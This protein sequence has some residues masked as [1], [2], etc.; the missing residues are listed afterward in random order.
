MYGNQGQN[1]QG[2]NQ[3]YNNQGMNNQGWNQGYNQPKPPIPFKTANVTEIIASGQKYSGETRKILERM[4][5]EH[6]KSI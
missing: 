3:G 5:N 1:N 2:Y 6:L 4:R